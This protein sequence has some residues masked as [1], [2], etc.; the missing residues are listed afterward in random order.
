MCKKSGGTS[1]YDNWKNVEVKKE[2]PKA[3][4]KAQRSYLD[5]VIDAIR[6]ALLFVIKDTT[7]MISMEEDIRTAA[8]FLMK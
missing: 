6:E 4:T 7:E 2:A 5:T 1:E 3:M 8:P